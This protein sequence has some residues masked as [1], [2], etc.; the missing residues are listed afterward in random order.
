MP[1][2]SI[3]EGSRISFHFSLKLDEGDIVD[4]NFDSSPASMTVGD[5]SL[6]AGF[7][8]ILIGLTAGDCK[9]AQIAPADAFGMPNP[10]NIQ[11][12]PRSSFDSSIELEDGLVVSF[13]DAAKN[14]L[15]GVINRFDDQS[16]TVDFNHPLA[17][18]HLLFE[19][20]I[21]EVE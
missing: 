21:L 9:R 7:E 12:L 15:P 10:E 3:K 18:R 17:G 14:E 13:A 2:V 19:V 16:V 1:D 5:G 4:S 20:Q 8:K 6:P 11:T